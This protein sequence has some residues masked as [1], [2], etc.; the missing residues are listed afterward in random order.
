MQ[1]AVQTIVSGVNEAGLIQNL[2]V[3]FTT[4]GVVLS[5]LMQNS[6]R[7][8]ATSVQFDFDEATKSLV[9]TDNGCGIDDWRVLLTI[10][11]SGWSEEV[12]QADRPYGM[13]FFSV[14]FSAENILVESRGKA[15]EFSADDLIAKRHIAV[16]KS[17]FIG[18]TRV[19][20][21]GFKLNA[22]MIETA[23]KR[24]ARGFELPVIWQGKTLPSPHAR[25]QLNGVMTDIG[26]VSHPCIHGESTKLPRAIEVYCQ[27]L[28][29]KVEGASSTSSYRWGD[30][31]EL[32]TVIH[33]DHLKFQP[34][35]PD[36]ECIVDGAAA[37]QA[38]NAVLKAMY[39]SFLE[40]QKSSMSAEAFATAYWAMARAVGMQDVMNDVP[41][42]PAAA[43]YTFSDTPYRT[44]DG[45][46]Y[47]EQ[48]D[49]G[50]TQAEVEAGS[51]ILMNDYDPDDEEEDGMIKLMTAC[52]AN[53]VMVEG[54]SKNH[55]ASQHVKHLGGIRMDA[56]YAGN[57]VRENFS[58]HYVWGEVILADRLHVSFADVD[59]D[60]E[61]P[62]VL[63]DVHGEMQ[64]IIP[65]AG[66]DEAYK[67]LRQASTYIDNRDVF[68]EMEYQ[69]DEEELENLV[70]V[71]A[72]ED[73]PAT[74][75]R[76]I[77]KSQAPSMANLRNQQFTVKFDEGGNVT[78][79][80][81]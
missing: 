34:R 79:V 46:S 67:V 77:S 12:M 13:G 80:A 25:E 18:G 22:S 49:I 76:L 35:M 51:V 74:L 6:R 53:W 40:R 5:E 29:V 54:L 23:L 41:F 71:M 36:R 20:M 38:I 1:T 61:T 14:A 56:T 62:V 21:N 48:R 2:K 19:T 17:E 7:A 44:S 75:L 50:V 63:G 32:T 60:I 9:V 3:M 65:R 24:F 39:Q 55:W 68:A 42:I 27:G 47:L 52:L 69:T 16:L 70:R 43:L 8:G 66:I 58:G 37:G 59:M 81:A 57:L 78:V 30:E 11:D 33:L 45:E 15:I 73:A 64:I 31:A 10:A 72:G 28:P 4:T 26:F